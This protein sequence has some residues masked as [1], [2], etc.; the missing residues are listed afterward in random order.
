ML[1]YFFKY[2]LYYIIL[3]NNALQTFI[4]LHWHQKECLW[5][6]VLV[7]RTGI[8]LNL[9]ASEILS[10]FLSRTEEPVKACTYDRDRCALQQ[11]AL[12]VHVKNSDLT[13]PEIDS[14][15]FSVPH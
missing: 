4:F 15:K 3:F 12:N 1:C 5:K 11:L 6:L 2:I 13:W 8:S 14:S 9:T 10:F 7:R